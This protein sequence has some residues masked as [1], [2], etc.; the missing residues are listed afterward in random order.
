ML[1]LTQHYAVS[2]TIDMTRLTD[3]ILA[4][5]RSHGKNWVFTPRHLLALGNRAAVDQALH[6]LVHQGVVRRVARGLYDIPV[7]HPTLGQLT[8]SAD[9]VAKAVAESSGHQ[10]QITP[11]RAANLLGLSTQV[12]A[13]LVYLTDGS[14][15]Q[16]KI[17]NQIL[18][19]K[20]ASRRTMLGAGRPVGVA[21]QAL[22][23]VKN[24]SDPDR[25]LRHLHQNLDPSVKSDL[26]RLASK[27][28]AS[29]KP[30]IAVVAV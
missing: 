20:H 17:G 19:L 15:R 28:P 13:R 6:R 10:L 7:D 14:S 29:I 26:R 11:A 21:Y 16:L 4:Y 2:D 3:K 22:R 24:S 25:A 18:Q 5:A 27:A 30:L 12:P 9:A 23:S 8:P 1:Y